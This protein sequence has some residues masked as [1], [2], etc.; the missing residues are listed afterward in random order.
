MTRLHVRSLDDHSVMSP[1][2][3]FKQFPGL[4]QK[5]RP[6]A[7]NARRAGHPP[8]VDRESVGQPPPPCRGPYRFQ[9][10]VFTRPPSD[11]H[12][13]KRVWPNILRWPLEER[14]ASIS[15]A[16]VH[17]QGKGSLWLGAAQHP[18]APQNLG[19][20]DWLRL[21]NDPRQVNHHWQ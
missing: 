5:P 19:Y 11:G 8:F 2:L 18:L 17:H 7:E 16:E 12:V 21:R 10:K 13:G 1:D 6:L 15:W 20:P 9:G 14:A 4:S 3:E